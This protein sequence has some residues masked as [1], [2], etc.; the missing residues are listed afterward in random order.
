M[1]RL[2]LL[3]AICF[4]ISPSVSAQ[5]IPDDEIIPIC[6]GQSISVGAP[7]NSGIYNLTIPCN[8]W[9][10]L[11]PY[12]DLY[13]IKIMS[14]TTFTFK[15]TPV[16]FD[17][18]DFGAWLNPNW[19]NIAATP[20]ANKRGSQNDPNQTG[21]YTLGLS[22]TATDLCETGGSTGYPEPGMV[23]YFSVQS[24]DEILIAID[25][26]SSTTLGYTIEFGGDAVLDCT[27]LGNSYGKC[28]VDEND[29]EEFYEADFLEDLTNDFPGNIYKFYGQQADAE[30]GNTNYISFPV[31]VDYNDGEATEIY[32]RIETATGGFVRV[33]KIF[34]YV[35][36]LPE[37]LTDEV[38]LPTVCDDDGDGLA[39]FDL[40]QSE[41]MFLNNPELFH[42]KYY[43]NE[44][45]AQAG[46]ANVITQPNNYIS[47]TATVYV[48]IDTEPLDGN[49][50]GCFRIGLI[51]LKVSDFNVQAQSIDIG[52]LCGNVDEGMLT[53]DL[54]ED[55]IQIV[56]NSEDY[57]ISFHTSQADA[58][59]AMNAIPNPSAYEIPVPG[60]TS[61]Y[62]RIQSSED[63]CFSVSR[64]NYI[65]AG[66]PALQDVADTAIC[67][68][69]QA[70]TVNYDLTQHAPQI[71][72]NPENYEIS[73]YLSFNDAQ[74]GLNPIDNPDAYPMPLNTEVTIYVRVE[75][76]GCVSVGQFKV[77]I[78]SN[79]L[80]TDLPVQE[81]CT[82]QI[83]GQLP[84]DL[85]Q[86]ENEW[87]NNPSEFQFSYHQTQQ[88]A[89]SAQNPITNPT[90]YLI[91][92]GVE[93]NIYVRIET[94]GSDCFQITVLTLQPGNTVELTTGLV[95]GLCDEDFNGVYNYN[96]TNL[97]ALLIGNP[98][99]L[100]FSYYLNEQNA[101]DNQNPIPQNQWNNYAFNNLPTELWVVAAT[102]AS[103]RSVPV[104]VEFQLGNTIEMLTTSLGPIEYCEGEV[105]NLTDF[106]IQLTNETAVFTYFN[107]LIDA[108]N[109][110]N[111]IGNYTTFI[112][113]G[114]NSVFVKIE[115][116]ERCSVIAEIQF[117]Y[118][119]IPSIE[120]NQSVAEICPG[121]TFEATVSS[122]DPN[123]VFVWLLDD[124]QVGEGSSLLITTQGTYTVIVTGQGGCENQD[125]I[126]VMAPAEPQIIGIETGPDYIIV[127]AT[128]DGN[129]EY[130]LDQIFWQSSPKFDH[131]I[132]GETYM[133]YVRSGGCMISGY[134]VTLLSITNFVSPNGDG[135]NDDWEVRG[136]EVTSDATLKIFDRYGK[137]FVDTH[138]AGDY[139]WNGKYLGRPVPSGD[140]WF[141][142]EIPGNEIIKPQK[143]VGHISVRN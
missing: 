74:N 109:N 54:T 87:V 131:L 38:Y 102:G 128:G 122:D 72:D 69:Q 139:Q 103:C 75:S 4:G 112:P 91:N 141:I 133:I 89:E 65:T 42:L 22:L 105:L 55:V 10:P 27:I 51:H 124:V 45:D 132:P 138:F 1:K 12:L 30:A 9:M 67:V 43:E 58:D 24:G 88:D 136:I 32:V 25:R 5:I 107:S 94:N 80:V 14:G 78:H 108:Q 92:V 127:S 59:N 7:E 8:E 98:T 49:S 40:I 66:G 60:N 117:K 114:D 97:N 6:D 70:G 143:F 28:D 84:Y 57:E 21:I 118:Y 15:V 113:N 50:A 37:I 36:K 2:L 53:V 130:S 121:E 61:I 123:A 106:E 119:P 90:A 16:G 104:K 115:K 63:D 129:L 111:P 23:K 20:V 120:L 17:D 47:G 18:Y 62:V 35:N 137:L 77:I 64:L 76:D 134:E 44:S 46:N 100:I 93:A 34:L 3:L 83:G 39:A 52:P 142:I 41:S 116:P 126:T 29:T 85:T 13:Y 95:L 79:P 135:Q 31:T 101:L 99:G 96:L 140:Y 33:L 86:H 19:N 56:P 110:N 81:F 125:F 26:W 68:D 71:V 73:Y 48:R 11:S 82:E